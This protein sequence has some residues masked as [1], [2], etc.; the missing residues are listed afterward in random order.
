MMRRSLLCLGVL[1]LV[2]VR[3][4]AAWPPPVNDSG[5]DY[6]DPANWPNDPGYKDD[7]K[8]WSF[9]PASILAQ[10]D[11]VTKRIGPGSH[12]DRAWAKTTGD[13]RVLIAYTDSGIEW[14]NGELV[15]QLFLNSGEL[16]PPAG[17]PGSDGV[18]Y[19][20][21]GDGRFNVQDYTTAVGH[22]LP[23]AAMICDSRV[24]DMN[25]NGVLDAQDLIRVFSNNMDDDGNGYADDISGWDFFHNDNDPADDT[26]F[27][28][29]TGSSQD[30]V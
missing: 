2:L 1:A 28:H 26:H 4:H 20:V 17:C 30:R 22:M 29:G 14:D 11:D 10:V 12:Y 27:G 23:A 15:N 18:T 7:W 25:G 9:V 24:S 3:A 13:P 6:S 21:N 5:F 8:F 16:P 19:D